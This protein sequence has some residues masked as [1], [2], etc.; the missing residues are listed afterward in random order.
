MVTTS[1]QLAVAYCE[2]ALQSVASC[3]SW[4]QTAQVSA[5]LY[6]ATI[7][8]IVAAVDQIQAVINV[9]VATL[10]NQEVGNVI[11][12]IATV[13]NIPLTTVGVTALYVVPT[14]KT[15]IV[16][17]WTAR[18]AAQNAPGGNAVANVTRLSDGAALLPTGT[19]STFGV[20]Q[21]W[22]F[23]AAVAT[24]AF[25]TVAAGDTVQFNVSVKD[26]GTENNVT[27]DLFGYLM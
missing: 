23:E 25:D 8:A 27:V 10:Q 21:A 15:L 24:R 1:F 12:P 11:S 18:N 6:S 14:G 7:A 26:S 19:L 3:V 17:G 22:Q 2:Q 16:T 13:T 9:L 4:L 5:P 20:N